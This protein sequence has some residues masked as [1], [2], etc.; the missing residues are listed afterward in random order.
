MGIPDSL[1]NLKTH[2]RR[3][4]CR[5]LHGVD[6]IHLHLSQNLWTLILWKKDEVPYLENNGRLLHNL[7]KL[8][9][10]LSATDRKT[11]AKPEM[12]QIITH[13]RAL[14]YQQKHNIL[15]NVGMAEMARRSTGESDK[16]NSYHHIGSDASAENLGNDQ[17]GAE[18]TR[19]VIGTRT[20]I[21]QTE[22]YG[23]AFASSEITTLPASIAEAGIS[24]YDPADSSMT[25]AWGPNGPILILRVTSDPFEMNA[26][27]IF[28]VQTNVTHQNGFEA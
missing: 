7:D 25:E 28:T 20:S 12:V 14:K 5:S 4:A 23:S 19:K 10:E 17:M 13:D 11:T 26:N 15:T 3:L 6:P 2:A 27:R 24:N 21:G 9:L 1:A 16:P 18:L 8:T 22:R